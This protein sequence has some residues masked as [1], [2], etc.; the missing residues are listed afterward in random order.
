MLISTP[1]NRAPSRPSKTQPE[2]NAWWVIQA[3]SRTLTTNQPSPAGFRPDSPC[4]RCASFVI[5]P[6]RR[7]A[8]LGGIVLTSRP[9]R[10]LAF[11][12]DHGP[13]GARST[14]DVEVLLDRLAREHRHRSRVRCA[15][16]L[17]GGA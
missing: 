15:T 3:V 5:V 4:S 8:I 2:P 11:S 14:V 1:R 7:V 13:A 16:G 17:G 12:A 10:T 6:S 9:A